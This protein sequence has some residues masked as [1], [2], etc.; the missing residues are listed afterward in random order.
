MGGEYGSTLRGLAA[1]MQGWA[2][3]E[4]GRIEEGI[5]QMHQGLAVEQALGAE[6]IR[7]HALILLAE[8]Y[9]KAGQPTEGLAV[10]EAALALVHNNAQHRFEAEIY[11]LKG[12]L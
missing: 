12:N 3:V 6:R 7:D 10:L 8:A 4:Q 5:R 11:R 9:G 1:T 2:L